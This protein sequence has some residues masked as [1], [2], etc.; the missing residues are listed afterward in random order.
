[1]VQCEK[2]S[3]QH[4]VWSK[5]Y[6]QVGRLIRGFADLWIRG[7]VDCGFVDLWI[8]G[9]VDLYIHGFVGPWIRGFVK[10]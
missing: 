8:R 3:R 10:V 5:G 9:F 1:M 6:T 4:T 7:F 2:C